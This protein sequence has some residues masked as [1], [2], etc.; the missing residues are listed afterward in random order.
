VPDWQVHP[1]NDTFYIIRES[2][3][4]HFEKP[5][6]YLIFGR[7]KVLLEDTGAGEAKTGAF[8]QNLIAQWAK[9]NKK[10]APQLVVIHSHGHGDHIAGDKDSQAMPGVQFIAATP[11]EVSK[12]AGIAT[13]P[14]D[15]GQIDLGDRV[16]D[17]IP[18]PR[19]ET[20]SIALYDRKTGIFMPG[21]TLYP[22]RITTSQA[23]L[24]AFVASAARM[25]A[26]VEAHPVAH[27]LGTHIEQS[28]TPYVDYPRGTTYQPEEHVL[29][30][31]RANVLEFND[32]CIRMAGKPGTIALPEVTIVARPAVR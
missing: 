25:A 22:G 6:L 21:D 7:D 9:K 24:P 32:A 17:V 19:H 16:I 4:I 13:W 29:E 5:F 2:G 26:F 3:C 30:L 8:I 15:P 11:P 28:R 31:T 23:Q 12:A 1:Y 20:A 18:I 27:V 14:T 10:A